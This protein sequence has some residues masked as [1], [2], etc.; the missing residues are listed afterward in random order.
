MKRLFGQAVLLGIG[1]ALGVVFLRLSAGVATPEGFGAFAWGWPLQWHW[2]ADM[3]DGGA[4]LFGL[5]LGGV[6]WVWFYEDL[7]FWTGLSLLGVEVVSYA[8]LRPL[9]RRLQA[10]NM[11]RKGMVSPAQKRTAKRLTN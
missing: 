10:H 11:D 8:G 1:F 5:Y 2:T 3:M 9:K 7:L 6:N 4:S